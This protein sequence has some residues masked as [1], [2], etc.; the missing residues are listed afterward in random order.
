MNSR[1]YRLLAF[2]IEAKQIEQRKQALPPAFV[3]PYFGSKYH[4]IV[5]IMEKI[6]VKYEQEGAFIKHRYHNYLFY[7]FSKNAKILFFLN[8]M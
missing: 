7:N 1:R 2:W 5:N 3:A 6:K 8:K 4:I